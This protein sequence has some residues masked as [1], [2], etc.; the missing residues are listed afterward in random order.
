MSVC[1]SQRRKRSVKPYEFILG[2]SFTP[3]AFF[4][5]DLYMLAC[6]HISVFV[7]EYP[8][9]ERAG[10]FSTLRCD[11]WFA[12]LVDGLMKAALLR[13]VE[14]L[15]HHSPVQVH[16][17]SPLTSSDFSSSS[18]IISS[19]HLKPIASYFSSALIMLNGDN[20]LKYTVLCTC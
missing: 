6:M 3:H 19:I 20:T 5:T 10:L 8:A 9:R 12:V 1:L 18:C 17:Y 2:E 4:S 14:R 15:I 16:I 11:W 13:L 7:R